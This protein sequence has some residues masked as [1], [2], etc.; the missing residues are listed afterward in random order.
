MKK[1]QHL[2]KRF[3]GAISRAQPSPA[4]RGEVESVLLGEEFDLW[5][6]MP[7]MDQR[8]SIVVM[9]RFRVLRPNATLPE[10]RAALLHDV[11]KIESNLGVF[12]RVIATVVGPRGRR[13]TKYHEHEQIG[14][15]MLRKINSELVTIL[16]VAGA[17]DSLLAEQLKMLREADN[18]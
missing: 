9:R 6:K 11:G 1:F 8:H 7:A 14:S 12:G 5:Q 10:I 15:Q 3:C 2:F 17:P 13:F 4:D 18:I 16:L